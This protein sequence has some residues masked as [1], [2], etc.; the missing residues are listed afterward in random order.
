VHDPGDKANPFQARL[1]MARLDRL[2]R[3]EA[4]TRDFAEP[5]AGLA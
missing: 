2:L 4:A 3:S 5:I 1:A